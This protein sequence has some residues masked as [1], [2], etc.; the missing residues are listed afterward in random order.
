MVLN[1]TLQSK[2]CFN[3]KF[4]RLL[5]IFPDDPAAAFLPPP[6]FWAWVF[7]AELAEPCPAFSAPDVPFAAFVPPPVFLAFV[8]PRELALPA[9]AFLAPDDPAAVFEPLPEFWAT[10][11]DAELAEP[12]P[13][14]LA[15]GCVQDA[16]SQSFKLSLPIN[17]IPRTSAT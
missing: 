14:F 12:C 16:R 10:V 1:F 9:P 4:C 7:E 3:T 5:H 2:N 6:V 13:A 17:L 8:F 15:P 11:L